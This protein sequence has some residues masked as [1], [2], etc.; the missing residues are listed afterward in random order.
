MKKK[1]FLMGTILAAFLM[2]GTA[3]ATLMGDDVDI[4]WVGTFTKAE[5]AV[6]GSG[7]EFTPNQFWNVD[8]T[9]NQIII[10]FTGGYDYTNNTNYSILISDID[11][12]GSDPVS[13]FTTNDSYFTF[14]NG[15]VSFE[16][17][18]IGSWRASHS[19]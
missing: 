14:N 8:V 5:D 16:L 18:S 17:A 11:S 4:Y 6:V 2:V 15:S 3:H 12:M 19:V 1:L 9:G 10:N 7:A 13:G